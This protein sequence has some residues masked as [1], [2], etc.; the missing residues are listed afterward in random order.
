MGQAAL[1]TQELYHSD[2]PVGEILRRTR[3]HYGQSLTDIERALRIRASQIEAIEKGDF[4][5]LPGRV[6]A[7]GFIR[8]YAEYLGLDGDKIV[9]IFKIQVGGKQPGPELHF[10]VG[11]ADTK[12]PQLWLVGASLAVFFIVL[13]FWWSLQTDNRDVVEQIPL[14]PGAEVQT[15]AMGPALPQDDIALSEDS[16]AAQDTLDAEPSVPAPKPAQQAGITLKV[17]RNSWVEIKDQKGEEIVSRVL[18]Q[19][20][21]YFVPDRPDLFMSLGNA[22]GI[23]IE[24]GGQTLDP[25][26][27]EGQVMRNIPLDSAYLKKNFAPPSSDDTS[28]ESDAN[29]S[30]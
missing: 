29:Q 1:K 4:E 3:L 25:L 23:Q 18:K 8:T 27:K 21:V 17:L 19:G 11:A 16:I 5:K 30:Q 28:S 2:I 13:L 15:D 24:I 9:D 10:P 22:N 7:I 6:Y 20:E 14:P 12:I 26:G